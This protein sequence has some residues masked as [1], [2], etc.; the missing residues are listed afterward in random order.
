[1]TQTYYPGR[2]FVQ[3]D[4][5]NDRE[6]RRQIAHALNVGLAGHINGSMSVTLG[7]LAATTTIYDATISIATVPIFAPT[8]PHAAAEIAAGSLYFEPTQGQCVVHHANNSQADRIFNVIL[9][10]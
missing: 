7:T 1:M 6:H 5:P 10:G 4:M 9:I 2:T 8:T 3:E